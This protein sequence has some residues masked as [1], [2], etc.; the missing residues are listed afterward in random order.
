MP[1]PSKS[2]GTERFDGLLVEQLR[3]ACDEARQVAQSEQG[4]PKRK[5]AGLDRTSAGLVQVTRE[6]VD[7][8]L[9][10]VLLGGIPGHWDRLAEIS[11][12]LADDPDVE[13]DIGWVFNSPERPVTLWNDVIGPMF[14]RYCKRQPDLSWDPALAAAIVAEW[15]AMHQ[16]GEVRRRT[17][18]PLH[19]VHLMP[20]VVNVGPGTV[21]R[22]M[23]DEDRDEMWRYTGGVT[24]LPNLTPEQ[25]DEWTNVIDDSWAMPRRLPVDHQ[26]LLERI[27]NVITALRLHHPGVT[28]TT[29]VWSRPDP[30]DVLL[31]QPWAQQTLLTLDASPTFADPLRTDIGPDDGPALTTLVDAVITARADRRLAL[32]LRRFDSA[33][34]RRNREDSFIDLWIAFEALL[35]PDGNQELTY[36]AALRI[37]RLA[38]TTPSERK[39]AFDL[40]KASYR[41]RSNIVHGNEPPADLDKRL[42][43]TRQLARAVLRAWVLNPP[44]GGVGDLDQA[45][46]A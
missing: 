8:K 32:A 11:A 6:E 31:P 10:G 14:D 41:L 12:K 35:L 16:P 13:G 28:G 29:W 19:N 40:A 43:D 45:M 38:G 37:A 34:E 15:R 1:R 23:T 27:T 39:E 21:I 18:A 25:L 44:P 5:V 22:P 3:L 4:L 26:A 20:E 42:F 17:I 30:P 46:L 36:R 2:R 33:Y 9:V 7:W 24:S